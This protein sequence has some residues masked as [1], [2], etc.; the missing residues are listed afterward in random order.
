MNVEITDYSLKT[1]SPE[2]ARCLALFPNLHTVVIHAPVD[3]EPL[4]PTWWDNILSILRQRKGTGHPVK[5]VV[6]TGES[7][8]LVEEEHD[9]ESNP[10]MRKLDV[11]ELAGLVDEVVDERAETYGESDC[12]CGLR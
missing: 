7:C 9:A 11:G 10:G 6:F 5:C 3:S 1:V 2:F 4:R 8:H 12:T